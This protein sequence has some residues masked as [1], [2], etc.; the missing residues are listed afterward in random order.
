MKGRGPGGHRDR[1]RD[2][3]MVG[4]GAL[5]PLL[6]R[7]EREPPRPQDLEHQLLLALAEDR[8]GQGDP[9]GHETRACCGWKAYSSESTRASHEASMMFSDTPMEPHSRS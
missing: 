2:A 5:E 1:V 4:E 3:E 8:L 9:L 7:P 6:H